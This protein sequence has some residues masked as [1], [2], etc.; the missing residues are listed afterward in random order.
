MKNNHNFLYTSSYAAME[1]RIKGETDIYIQVSRNLGHYEDPE[2]TTGLAKKIDEDWGEEFGNWWNDKESYKKGISKKDLRRFAKHLRDIKEIHTVFLLCF[3]NVLA[4]EECH[5][6]W[7]AE[8]L[9]KGFGLNIPEWENK[10]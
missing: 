4:G 5:R 7:L 1:K 10:I 8:I 3:E 9:Q 6:R 2:D